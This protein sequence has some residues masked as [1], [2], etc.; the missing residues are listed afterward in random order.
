MGIYQHADL[1]AQTP[2]IKPAQKHKQN[3][4]HYKYTKKLKQKQC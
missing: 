2:I 4:E 1:S 3:T